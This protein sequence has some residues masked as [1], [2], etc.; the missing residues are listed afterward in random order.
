[1]ADQE[2]VRSS[3]LQVKDVN[4][5]HSMKP[6]PDIPLIQHNLCEDITEE[7]KSKLNSLYHETPTVFP[8]IDTSTL[9]SYRCQTFPLLY[10]VEITSSTPITRSV[11]E[12]GKWLWNVTTTIRKNV[13]NCVG[14]VDK[15][16]P[17]PFDMTSVSSRRGGLQLLN[18]VSVFRRFDEGDQV[19]LVGTAKW[20]L[21]S[22]GLV[23]QDYNWTV[24]SPSTNPDYDC[25]ARNYY[26][27]EATRV[28]P[29]KTEA[30]KTILDLVGNRMRIITQSMQ[31]TSLSLDERISAEKSSA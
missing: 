29:A 28:S 10:C 18:T 16:T 19:V 1:M 11:Q 31:D 22:A 24:I 17:G 30:Q 13:I 3:V 21:P 8:S 5:L 7:L 20:Y 2:S 25:V 4:F 26:K 12:T 27:V 9:V 23:L 15:K 6:R 14:Y